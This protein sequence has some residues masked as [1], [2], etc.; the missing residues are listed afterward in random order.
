MNNRRRYYNRGNS[1]NR[2]EKNFV[3]PQVVSI[4]EIYKI[5]QKNDGGKCGTLLFSKHYVFLMIL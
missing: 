5:G 4:L 3:Q 1:A 2:Y